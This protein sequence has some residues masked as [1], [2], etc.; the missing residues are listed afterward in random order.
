VLPM[1]G[2]ELLCQLPN[3]ETQHTTTG[4]LIGVLIMCTT[5]ISSPWRNAPAAYQRMTSLPRGWSWWHVCYL[6]YTTFFLFKWQ[7]NY[8]NTS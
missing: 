7:I 6:L 1:N 2:S 8:A 4:H 5:I 3:F